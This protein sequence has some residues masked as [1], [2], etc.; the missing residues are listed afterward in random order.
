MMSALILWTH[1][2]AA[3]VFG[4]LGVSE[5]R[6]GTRQWPHRAF[7]AALFAT[8][9]WALAVAGIG[10]GDIATRI[11]RVNTHWERSTSS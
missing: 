3:L 5:L 7:V 8:S 1:A 9:L 11:G 4:A 6:S 10:S 2:L